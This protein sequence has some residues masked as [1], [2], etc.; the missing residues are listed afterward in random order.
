MLIF[1][2]TFIKPSSAESPRAFG[3]FQRFG[4]LRSPNFHW[5]LAILFPSFP[6]VFIHCVIAFFL[7]HVFFVILFC[8]SILSLRF[9]KPKKTCI[10]QG[11]K[12]YRQLVGFFLWP[13]AIIGSIQTTEVVTK[14]FPLDRPQDAVP[15]V[16]LFSLGDTPLSRKNF[17]NFRGNVMMRAY[18]CM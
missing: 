13:A 14:K 16:G 18:H 5:A 10:G 1:A 4:T 2:S 9:W 15:N 12:F 7:K 17:R 3:G 8:L 6:L 11:K